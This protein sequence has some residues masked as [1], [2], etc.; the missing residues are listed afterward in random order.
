MGKTNLLHK[1]ILAA[2]RWVAKHRGLDPTLQAKAISRMVFN[3]HV[4]PGRTLSL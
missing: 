1:T 4:L 3:A 2:T